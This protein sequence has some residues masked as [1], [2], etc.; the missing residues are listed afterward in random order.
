LSAAHA[1]HA[2]TVYEIE[3]AVNDEKFIINGNLYEAKTY[4]LGWAE[5]DQV[6]FVEGSPNGICVS[7]I[8]FNVNR[9]ESCRV[10]CE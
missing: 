7:A 4:C 8:L 10:W 3:A 9:N 5:G 2:A 1:A 6:I